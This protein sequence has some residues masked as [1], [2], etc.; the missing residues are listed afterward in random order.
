MKKKEGIAVFMATVMV[1]IVLITTVWSSI[2]TVRQKVSQYCFDELAVTSKQLAEDLSDS[3]HTDS[4]MMSVMAEVIAGMDHVNTVTLLSVMNSFERGNSYVSYIAVLEP[5]GQLLDQGGRKKDVSE[6]LNFEEEAQKGAY[7]SERE[8][9]FFNPEKMIVHNAVPIIRDGETI[10]IIY[11]VISLDEL[12]QTYKTDIYNGKAYV[13]V[14]NGDTGDFL[15]D[16]WHKTLGNASELG[17]R[18]ALN[19]YDFNTFTENLQLGKSGNICFISNT[20]GN[21]LYIHHE[22]TGINNWNILVS[23]EEG[24]VFAKSKAIGAELYKMAAVVAVTLFVYMLC[25]VIWLNRVYKAM[26][27]MDVQDQTTRLQNRNAY[28]A[29]KEKVRSKLFQRIVCIYIDANGLHEINN[30]YGHAAGDKMLQSIADALKSV[31][32]YPI[33][34]RIG[35]DE[36][37][38]FSEDSDEEECTKKIKEVMGKIEQSGY[39]VSVGIACRMDEMGIDGV[40]SEADEKMLD[41]KRAYYESHEQRELRR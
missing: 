2:M 19:G 26:H 31:F 18:K 20:T 30:Q 32:P 35:G 27:Q 5:D 29:Y 3:V 6:R 37:V 13:L 1:I 8:E 24:D 12:A 25:V 38:V 22:P 34:Y 40:T 21:T 28:D 33:L 36:F 4:T 10:A 17:K 16:T 9:D 41:N 15:L 39:S 23:V 11:G 14:E 7:I